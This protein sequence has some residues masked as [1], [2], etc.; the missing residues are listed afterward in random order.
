MIEFGRDILNSAD[1]ATSREWLV[2]NGIGGFASGTLAGMNTRTY[3]ALLVAALNPPLDRHVLVSGIDEEITY[4]DRRYSLFANQWSANET[5]TPGLA[6]LET[7]YLEGTMPVWTFRIEDALLEK[8][9]WMAQGQNTTYVRYTMLSGSGPMSVGLK[10]LVNHRDFHTV[11]RALN[12]QMQS[13][14]VDNGLK[15]DAFYEAQPI[16]LL[17]KDAQVWAEHT[18]FHDFY[19][20]TE[21]YRGLDDLDDNLYAAWFGTELTAGK[22]CT[23]VAS[24]EADPELNSKKALKAA[25]T[26]E[27]DLLKTAGLKRNSSTALQQL[28]LAANQFIV[29]RPTL[30]DPEGKTIIAGYPWFADWGRDTMIALNGLTLMTGRATVARQILLT[31]QQFIDEGMLPNRFVDDNSE[32][33]YNTVDATL[34][35]FQAIY[36]YYMATDDRELVATLFETLEDI[37]RWHQLGT[38]YNIK[39]DADGLLFA[40]EDGVQLTWMDAKVDEFVVTPRIGKPVEINALWYNALN[41]LAFFA[42]ELEKD[43]LIYERMAT[44]V[45]EG[46][47]KFWNAEMSYCFDV[48]ETPNGS[49]DPALRPN[50][51]FAVSLPFSPLTPE[52]QKAVVDACA[53]DLVTP[54]GLR[55]LSARHAE[56]IGDYGGDKYMRDSAYHQGT[57]WG[58]LISPFV[59]AHLRVYK[60]K[61]AAKHYLNPLL[62]NLQNHCVGSL[63]E[64]FDG[65][66]PYTPR[67][68]YAQAWSVAAALECW[69]TI[70]Q[71][72]PL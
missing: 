61:K 33:A 21:H 65:N 40:G 62:N 48:I 49:H 4:K 67:G 43:G 38:R 8:R 58:W 10:T 55:S 71:Y 56:Y 12:W 59:L 47:E 34:W 5:E 20:A 27:K 3:H 53:K 11:T 22:S 15:I 17:S 9:I 30:D 19:L 7:F 64:I 26:H 31:Y 60:D 70:D 66:A 32:P 46:F 24:T 39:Q 16:Y 6:Y 36:S 52:Q 1:N 13:S 2:T 51:L 72:Q 54:H 68:A 63:S 18:W 41:I 42:D 28:T 44:R 69:H 14:R 50:Q 25:Q 23:V 29:D 35:Y 37:V 57:V 45:A